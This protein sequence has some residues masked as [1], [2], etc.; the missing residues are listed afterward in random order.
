LE[1]ARRN[2]GIQAQDVLAWYRAFQ[3]DV[4]ENSTPGIN[5][6]FAGRSLENV[7]NLPSDA[8][9][10]TSPLVPSVEFSATSG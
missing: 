1:F 9:R 2:S 6:K 3:P 5:G 8:T 7:Q 10:R 4:A